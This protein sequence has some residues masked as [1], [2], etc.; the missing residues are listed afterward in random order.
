MRSMLAWTGV[1][2]ALGVLIGA[3]GAHGMPDHL[4]AR[5]LEADLIVRRLGQFDVG[6]RYH[7]VHAVAMLAVVSL[8]ELSPRVRR[9]VFGLMVSGVILF[10]GSLYVLVAT[11]TPWLG[12]ITPLGGVSWIAAWVVLASA[13]FWSAREN[14]GDDLG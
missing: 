5:G 12:A 6:V 2:G 4:A 11:N 7:L 3:F 10:S 1:V 8:R 13:G 9:W 14:R